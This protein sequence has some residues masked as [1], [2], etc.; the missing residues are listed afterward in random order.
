[1]H[2]NTFH[3]FCF[4]L[5]REYRSSKLLHLLE[6]SE[7]IHMFLEN[8]EDLKPFA[9]DEFPM[10]PQKTVT[11]CF[12]PFFN[13]MRDELIDPAKS[14]I[15]EHS[16]DGPITVEIANQIRDL[17]RIYPIFQSWKRKNDQET[18]KNEKSKNHENEKNEG[19][20]GK[21]QLR[22]KT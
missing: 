3:S 16:V 12:I 2:V 21:A 6:T 17:K 11:D 22:E 20:N 7:A 4:K 9:S 10:D 14:E 18:L 1:M 15:P 13:R 19:G 8:F 5:L